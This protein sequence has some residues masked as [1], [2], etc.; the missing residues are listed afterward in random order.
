MAR[1]NMTRV[2][3]LSVLS[4]SCVSCILLLAGCSKKKQPSTSETSSVGVPSQFR[5]LRKLP[6]TVFDVTYTPN[7]VRIDLPTVQKTLQSLSDDGRV[8]VFDASDSRLRELAEGKIMFLEHLGVRRVLAVQTQ[9][10]QI[11]VLTEPAALTDFIQD[12]NIQFSVP[13]NFRE[14]QARTTALP[15]PVDSW[16]SRISSWVAP[17]VAYASESE[18][19]LSVHTKGEINDWEFEIEGEPEKDGLSL[20]LEAAKKKLAGLTA[21]VTA[22]GEL[23]H[24]STAF[25]VLIHGG[26]MQSFEY[27]TPIQGH[28]NVSWAVLTNGANSGIGEARLKLPPF[29][30]DVFDIYGIPFLFKIDEALIFKPGF[31][32][33]KDAAE[34]G[35]HV[36]YDGSGGLAI[37]G[38]QSSPQGS[39]NAEPS[40][41]KTTAESLA[42][43]GVVL[44]INAPKVSVSLGTESMKE[45]IKEA[46]PAELGDKVAELLEKGPFGLGGLVKSVKEDFFKIEGAAYLQL[47][48][49]FDYAGSGPLSIVPCS[50]THL[51]FYAQAGA[52]ATLFALKG[53]SPKLNLKETKLTFR[54]PDID[55]CGQK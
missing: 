39:I 20:S 14:L 21:S 17:P 38:D 7:T 55:A 22:K 36:T 34:G 41:D 10:S 3:A 19:K 40:P 15:K 44:A 18:P 23:Q 52:D 16:A 48:T 9:A 8:F 30:K 6:G 45:A 4:L 50:M 5:D 37:H 13:V 12:G 26:K 31:G 33:K 24:V 53:E 27:S 11:A 54:E 35:F 1:E 51:N 49:E 46:L 43:H 32:G 47:V 28:L 25:K 42:A 29:A 2:L